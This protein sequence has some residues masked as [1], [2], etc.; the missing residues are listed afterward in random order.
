M[1]NESNQ[2][3]IFPKEFQSYEW[4]SINR[5]IRMIIKTNDIEFIGIN[6]RFHCQEIIN[7]EKSISIYRIR[8]ITNWY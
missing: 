8:S 7:L 2:L 1:I 6:K 5:T 3:C 4:Y